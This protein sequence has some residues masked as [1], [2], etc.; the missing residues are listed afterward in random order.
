MN[1]EDAAL[2]LSALGFGAV[3]QAALRAITDRRKIGADTTSILTAAAR[4]LVEPLRKELATEREERAAEH[5]QH[6]Q[7]LREE[8]E[9][10]AGLRADLDAALGE[11]RTLR[12]SLSAAH[13]ELTALRARLEQ[14]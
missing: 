6:V 11:A 1:V 10:A 14:S 2:V 4:E 7:E 9:A 12:L 5:Q 3:A 8:R 13:R